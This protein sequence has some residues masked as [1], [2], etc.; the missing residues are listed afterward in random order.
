MSLPYTHDPVA[1]ASFVITR[2]A[3]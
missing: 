1:R 3:T 2:C